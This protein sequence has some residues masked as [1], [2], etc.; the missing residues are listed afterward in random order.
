MKL[1]AITGG[2]L[3]TDLRLRIEL[4]QL[5]IMKQSAITQ[6]ELMR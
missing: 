6:L 1:H 3:D 2:V 5:Q 4:R